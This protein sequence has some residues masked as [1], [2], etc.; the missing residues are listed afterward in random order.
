MLL[1]FIFLT[2]LVPDKKYSQL[3]CD[4]IKEKEKK[5]VCTVR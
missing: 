1:I 4:K 5:K 2:I 3:N